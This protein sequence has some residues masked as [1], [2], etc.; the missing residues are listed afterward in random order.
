MQ[1]LCAEKVLQLRWA[2][3]CKLQ[4]G[5]VSWWCSQRQEVR[6]CSLLTF[7]W[8]DPGHCS[9]MHAGTPAQP[10]QLMRLL[11]MLLPTC[12]GKTLKFCSLLRSRRTRCPPESSMLPSSST[13]HSFRRP[14][15][16]QHTLPTTSTSSCR[17]LLSWWGRAAHQ[18]IWKASLLQPIL[19]TTSKPL[20]FAKHY[21]HCGHT[22]SW[23]A[24]FLQ[25]MLPTISTSFCKAPPATWGRGAHSNICQ[26]SVLQPMP[27]PI[28]TSSC[29]TG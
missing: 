16:S 23:Q 12:P 14:S 25:P 6:L 5:G 21:C 29:S 13:L 4:P 24:S 27:A 17:E 19:P 3:Y 15:L 11:G 8:E 10:E 28:S 7:A 20:P 22:K 2:E 9:L 26:A 18:N 1:Q